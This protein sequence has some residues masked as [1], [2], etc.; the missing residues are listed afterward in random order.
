MR[1]IRVYAGGLLV[2]A[3]LVLSGCGGGGGGDYVPPPPAFD[4][5]ILVAGQPIFGVD[6]LPGYQQTIYLAVG[7]TFELDSSGPVA[8]AVVVGGSA[9]PESG[10]TIDYGGARIQEVLTTTAQFA[11][12]TGAF[13]PLAAP[14]LVTLY[15]TSLLDASQVATIDLILTN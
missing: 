4:I 2:S 5:G 9:V 3:A 10:A 8:W 13:A 11:A 6:V 12:N 14:V 1:P 15:A 7:Q